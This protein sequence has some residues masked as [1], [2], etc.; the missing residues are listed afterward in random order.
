MRRPTVLL[1]DDYVAITDVIER[2]LQEHFDVVGIVADGDALFAAAARLR[3]DVIVTDVSM[4]KLSGVDG[5]RQLRAQHENSR[6]I[7]L[8]MHADAM[9]AAEA[10]RL[11]ANGFVLKQTSGEE[12]VKAIDQV[13]QGHNYLSPALQEDVLAL[14]SAPADSHG[15]D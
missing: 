14:T 8:T 6:I 1:A 13:L 4:P 2:I 11:G 7:V 3:P 15:G 9:L 10:L 12:L 5:L